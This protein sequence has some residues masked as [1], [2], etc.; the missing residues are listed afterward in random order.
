[1]T[2]LPPVPARTPWKA[3]PVSTIGS[4]HTTREELT[5]RDLDLVHGCAGAS[6]DDLVDQLGDRV[7]AA[8][9]AITW[10]ATVDSGILPG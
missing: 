4:D 6:P 2:I 10:Q 9:A 3:I 5:A 1:M 7:P 8:R